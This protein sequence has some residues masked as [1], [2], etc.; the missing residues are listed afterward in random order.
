MKL[1]FYICLD[2]TFINL[3]NRVLQHDRTK[4]IL[5]INA[6]LQILEIMKP[7]SIL[8]V[9][10]LFSCLI[11]TNTSCNKNTDCKA[12][13]KCVD[14]TGVAVNNAFVFLYAAVKSPDG[15]TTYTGDVTASGNT[16]SGGEIKFTFQLPAIFDIRATSVVGT[17]T[18]VGQSI[19]KLEEGKTSQKTVTLK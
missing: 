13:V 10:F 9:G 17:K 12:E 3:I 15:K 16:D 11:F 2:N 1:F 4:T 19:I 18:I 14:S 5:R 7:F 8:I 6:K